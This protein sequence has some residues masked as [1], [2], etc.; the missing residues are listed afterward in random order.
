[1]NNRNSEIFTEML[2]DL[3][4]QSVRSKNIELVKTDVAGYIA[5]RQTLLVLCLCKT[6]GWNISVFV[7]PEDGGNRRI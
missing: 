2:R 1:M 4:Y 3:I 6:T 7:R 5:L